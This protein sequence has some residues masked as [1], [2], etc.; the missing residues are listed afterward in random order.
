[1]HHWRDSAG[2]SEARHTL[3]GRTEEVARITE[4]AASREAAPLILVTGPPGIGRSAVLDGVREELS[5]RGVATLTL[6][7]SRIERDRPL[8]LVSRLC[9]ELRALQGADA[10]RRTAGNAPSTHRRPGIGNQLTG[11]LR[12]LQAEGRPLTV[13]VDDVQWADPGSRKALLP[14]VHTLAGGCVSFVC[15]YRPALSDPDGG[16]AALRRLCAAGL[17]EVTSLRP[18]PAA[19]VSGLVSHRLQ[20][21]PSA[22]LTGHLRRSCR[23]VPGAVHA[24][25]DG[26][27]RNG[28][29]RVFDRHA[30]LVSPDTPPELPAEQPLVEQVRQLGGLAWPVAKSLAVLH[31]LGEA[32]PALI[33][34]A[35]D[36]KESEVREEL[37]LLW[38]E[39][40]LQR[41]TRQSGWRF[42]LPLLASALTAGLG[43]YERRKLAALGVTAVWAGEATADDAHLADQLA[44]AGGF[45]DTRRAAR[46]LI[47]RS[48]EAML[49]DGH[50]AE[51][52]LRAAVKLTAEPGEH[53][54]ALLLH[55]STCYIH[56]RYAEALESAWA[57]IS[58]HPDQVSSTALLEAELVYV[59]SVAATS[60]T[61]ALTELA[62]DGW[63]SLP[64]GEGHRTIARC[65]A[66]YH[67]DRWREADDH[68]RATYDTWSSGDAVV[69]AL[70]H[71]FSESIAAVLGRMTAFER[72]VADPVHRPLW[73]QGSRHRFE[74]LCGLA[75]TLLSCGELERATR[76]L[77]DYGLQSGHWPVADQIV[78]SSL[79]GD[80][81]RSL[82]LVRMVLAGDSLLAD[83]PSHTLMCRAAS[84]MFISRGRLTQARTVLDKARHEQPV[85]LHLLAA[86]ESELRHVLGAADQVDRVISEAID[87]AARGGVVI[88]TEE[89]WLRKVRLELAGGDR[90]AARRYAAEA[91]RVSDL[92]GTDRALLFRLLTKAVAHADPRAADEALRLARRRGQPYELAKT[93]TALVRHE[94]TDVAALREAYELYGELDALLPR[95]RLRNLMSSRNM[96]VPGR[97]ATIAENERLLA[98]LVTEGLTNSELAVV[99]GCSQK[100][101]ESRLSRLFKRT[102]YLSRVELVSAVVSGAYPA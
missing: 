101:V 66:L 100:S 82:D 97:D 63:R 38:S 70:G 87:S 19:E 79:Q 17:A 90:A 61:A 83:V 36:V 20:A 10:G 29:L 86:P 96:A 67:L 60:D 33:A 28:T 85:M 46:E 2:N 91:A 24:A 43:E 78:A 26:H 73:E 48:V 40:V 69:A 11:E 84:I 99:L 89:L 9:A 71:F 102:G 13:F 58:S 64:G 39:G 18:L 68:L 1:M 32:A 42:R 93:V 12:A 56:H 53:T 4:A 31:P 47:A 6:R 5:A 41:G 57:V 34:R 22:S 7:M 77:T 15:A 16:P 51:R 74:R 76:L 23:G 8:G 45:V 3:F 59:V 65:A 37:S 35:L 14:A 98:T 54:R 62:R 49:H 95:A 80:W 50:P 25:L 27:R 52:W 72:S 75:R 94:L 88:G 55:A 21:M 92:L 44:L 30:Y 81:D